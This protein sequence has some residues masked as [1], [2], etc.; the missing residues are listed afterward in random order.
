MIGS[1]LSYHP[2]IHTCLFSTGSLPFHPVPLVVRPN[3]E[4][5]HS[6]LSES[7]EMV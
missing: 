7:Y 4:D 2:I 6:F 1:G 3:A 5:R